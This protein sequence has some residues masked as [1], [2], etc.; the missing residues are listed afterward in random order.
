[1]L[2]I[3]PQMLFIEHRRIYYEEN[4]VKFAYSLSLEFAI[5]ATVADLLFPDAAEM[6]ACKASML[7]DSEI[8]GKL[9]TLGSI[10]ASILL[11]WRECG[12]EN[13]GHYCAIA[14][15]LTLEFGTQIDPDD[16]VSAYPMTQGEAEARRLVFWSFFVFDR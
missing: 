10:Q 15:G 13:A 1:M 9:T 5:Y 16:Y 11:G 3:V 6:L 7:L 4:K 8:K 12:T 14:A 2:S